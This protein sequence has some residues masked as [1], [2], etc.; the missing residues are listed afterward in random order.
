MVSLLL[1]PPPEHERTR[2]R[3]ELGPRI[4]ALLF[5]FFFVTFLFPISAIYSIDSKVFFSLR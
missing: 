4:T 3:D 1:L 5:F 2:A